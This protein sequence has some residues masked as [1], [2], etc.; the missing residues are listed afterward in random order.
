MRILYINHVSLMSGAEH[1]LLA[2]LQRLPRDEFDPVV[3]LPCEG[4]LSERLAS[5]H[6]RT[7]FVPLQRFRRSHHP[8]HI[9]S[10][11]LCIV[12]STRHLQRFL[13]ENPVD[14]IHANSTTAHFVAACVG[15]KAMCPVIWHVRDLTMIP[16]GRRFLSRSATCVI[17]ISEAV[18]QSLARQG[19]SD[20][21][22]RVIHNGVDADTF[23]PQVDGSAVRS[24]YHVP[25]G[26]VVFG[27]VG[28]LIPWKQH[29]LFVTAA[30][31]VAEMFPEAHFWIVG[32]DL[33]GDH[34]DYVHM[35]HAKV[36][37]LHLIERLTF[38]GYQSEMPR[39]MAGMDVLVLPSTREPF[40]RV[41]IEAMACG[42][43]VIAARAAGPL[44]IVEEGRQGLL[45]APND[46]SAFAEAMCKMM[47]S[48]E[49]RHAWGEAARRRAVAEFGID[50]T[51]EKTCN[52]YRETV[53][54]R[55]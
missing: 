9:L 27:M 30:A 19:I 41:L 37:A 48:P 4:V 28:Q 8:R 55:P 52:L 45:V 51:V 23:N 6:I 3:A 10:A 14:L 20:E 18:R 25:E 21:K 54:H 36:R 42:K 11:L 34:P 47:L 24:Q 38:L 35:L 16:F 2:L 15:T 40:G 53:S 29:D 43:P 32:E 17:A 44:E 22:V 39:V 46:P 33:F 7:L 1:S 12:R 50:K 49:R 31:R 5:L 13:R 26:C